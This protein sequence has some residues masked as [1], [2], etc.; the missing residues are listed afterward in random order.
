MLSHPHFNMTAWGPGSVTFH[1]GPINWLVVQSSDNQ[2]LLVG[3]VPLFFSSLESL[4][5]GDKVSVA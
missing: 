5:P 3:Y 1:T 4:A 2:K